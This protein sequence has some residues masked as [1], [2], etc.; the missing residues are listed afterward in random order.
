MSHILGDLPYVK[1]YLDDVLLL[2]NGS[3]EDYCEKL[4]VV[5]Q[6]LDK[7]NFRCRPDKCHSAVDRVNTWDMTLAETD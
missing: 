7:Y 2:T 4:Q 1:I 6:R 5:L 3:Y